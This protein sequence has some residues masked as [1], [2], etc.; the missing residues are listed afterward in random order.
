[1]DS[2]IKVTEVYCSI[3]L[4]KSYIVNNLS[5]SDGS[6]YNGFNSSISTKTAKRFTKL[7]VF[8]GNDEKNV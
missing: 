8:N 3:S 6:K 4:S 2:S 5:F 7:D 1:M